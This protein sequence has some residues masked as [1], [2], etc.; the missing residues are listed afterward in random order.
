MDE[1]YLLSVC[2]KNHNDEIF[3]EPYGFFNSFEDAEQFADDKISELRHNF[4]IEFNNVHDIDEYFDFDF[5]IKK[6][7]YG[8]I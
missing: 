4:S 6:I 3:S 8:D 7:K 5:C 2:F 1:K